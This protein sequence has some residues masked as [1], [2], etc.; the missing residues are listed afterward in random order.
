MEIDLGTLKKSN[1]R[2]IWPNEASDFTPWLAEDENIAL[3]GE[4]I[5]IELEVENTEVAVGPY[6]A[7]ILAK[8]TATDD[9]VVIENQLKKTDHDHLGKSITY[10]SAL[11]AKSI[12]WIASQFT[13]E[14]QK[15]LEWLNDITTDEIGFFAIQLEVWKIDDSKPAVKFDVISRP[16]SL[17]RETV[18]F[19]SAGDLTEIKKTQLEFWTEFRSRL[20]KSKVFPSMPMPKPQYGYNLA[21]GRAGINLFC[22]A[23]TWGKKIGIR[24]VMISKVGDKALDQ[25]LSQKQEI[26]LEIGHNLM[27]NPNPNNKEKI[28]ELHKVGDITYKENWKELLSWLEEMAIR[29]RKTFAPRVKALDI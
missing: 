9:Y 27:W 17:K 21:L 18:K 8:D 2:R 6:S 10:A 29:F 13:E 20:S 23:D 22:Y 1:V 25:L 19:S 12:V 7:D 15:A 4:A 14:H 16:G 24:V 11:N 28:I 3:L 26:E 5:G